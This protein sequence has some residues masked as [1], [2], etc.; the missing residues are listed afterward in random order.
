MTFVFDIT[1]I[2]SWAPKKLESTTLS[3]PWAQLF[4]L[5]AKP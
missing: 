4:L 3:F 1:K 5:R 2:K